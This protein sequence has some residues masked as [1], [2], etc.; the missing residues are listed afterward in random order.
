MLLIEAREQDGQ[1]LA[2]K[3]IADFHRV[4]LR[5]ELGPGLS[6]FEAEI[7]HG[8]VAQLVRKLAWP[9]PLH[10]QRR[11]APALGAFAAAVLDGHAGAGHSDGRHRFGPEL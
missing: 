5:V 11:F 4:A 6:E 10:A 2:L 9:D 3:I 1:K 8:I 7:L